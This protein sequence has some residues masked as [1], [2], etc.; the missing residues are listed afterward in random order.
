MRDW[1]YQY[2]CG[3]GRGAQAK[4]RDLSG[5]WRTSVERSAPYATSREFVLLGPILI[6]PR[7]AVLRVRERLVLVRA[8]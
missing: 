6:R 4:Y 1:L 3:A 7:L 5:R 8:Q 2:Y